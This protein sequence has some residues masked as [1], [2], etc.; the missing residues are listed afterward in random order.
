[1]RFFN[2]HIQEADCLVGGAVAAE[3]QVNFAAQS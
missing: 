1:M 2:S 3:V